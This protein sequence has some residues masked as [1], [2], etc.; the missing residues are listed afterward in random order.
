MCGES[1]S[2]IGCHSIECN[3]SECSPKEERREEPQWKPASNRANPEL[4]HKFTSNCVRSV[5]GSLKHQKPVALTCN[6]R[7]NDARYQYF[8]KVEPDFATAIWDRRINENE[9]MSKH[10]AKRKKDKGKDKVGYRRNHT[11]YQQNHEVEYL[12]YRYHETVRKD[13]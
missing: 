12:M 4:W 8:D 5:K 10:R 2:A 7:Y 1:E 11:V 13:P 9:L 3:H 6:L